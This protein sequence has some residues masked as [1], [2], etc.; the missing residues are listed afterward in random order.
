MFSMSDKQRHELVL[1]DLDLGE[2]PIT[3]SV[4]LVDPG[5]EVVEGDRLLEVAAG[6]VTVDL[7]APAS[8][9]LTETLVAEDDQLA[10]GQVLGV[11]VNSGE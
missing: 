4:W 10:V 5:Q 8:G 3:A 7:P 1:P 9:I 6:N 2:I 11:I